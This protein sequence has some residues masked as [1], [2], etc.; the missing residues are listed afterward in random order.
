MATKRSG[1]D[2]RTG[3]SLEA[4]R[5]TPPLAW[6]T[7]WLGSPS[8]ASARTGCLPTSSGHSHTRML[9]ATSS[10][11]AWRPRSPESTWPG[12]RR[13]FAGRVATGP[14]DL[15]RRRGRRM[16]HP[17]STLEWSCGGHAL[18]GPV[19]REVVR[20][21]VLPA[22]PQH[23]HPRAGQ[24]A[25]RVGMMAAPSARGGVDRRRPGRGMAGVVGETGERLAEAFVARPAKGDAAVLA[26]FTGE[27]RG[28]WPAAAVGVL[29]EEPCE[30]FLAEPLGAVR[31]GIAA[32]EGQG[33]GR[34]DVG[35]DRGG[36]GPETVEQRPELIGEGDALGDQ[37]VAA[38]HQ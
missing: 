23:A 37:V 15:R 10:G 11:A 14:S 35:E 32:E 31:G 9:S 16:R 30:P 28:G 13:S 22:A 8:A 19:K 34:I 36:P 2:S 5:S 12:Q 24:D 38:P 7:S 18:G 1:W 29:H 20:A 4:R 6:P 3:W 21:A 17:V 26:G 33:D 27:G 25:D